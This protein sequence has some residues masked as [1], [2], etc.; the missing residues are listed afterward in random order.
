MMLGSF[1]INVLQKNAVSEEIQ[2]I[3]DKATNIEGAKREL[4]LYLGKQEADCMNYAYISRTVPATSNPAPCYEL[5]IVN[6]PYDNS[7]MKNYKFNATTIIEDMGKG[8]LG[9]IRC[10]KSEEA[11]IR[12]LNSLEADRFIR[13]FNSAVDNTKKIEKGTEEEMALVKKVQEYHYDVELYLGYKPVAFAN[14][15]YIAE[16]KNRETEVKG[17]QLVTVNNPKEGSIIVEIKDIL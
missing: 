6:V 3:F 13:T 17:I 8:M 16:V 15:Y 14:Y 5:I 1:E 7:N 12:I 9:G 11:T 10:S 2:Q 4:M